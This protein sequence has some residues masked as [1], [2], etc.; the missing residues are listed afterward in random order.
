VK[1]CRSGS[2][3]TAAALWTGG[4]DSAFALHLALEAGYDVR[5]LVT[6]VPPR[7]Q[8]RAHPLEVMRLQAEALGLEHRTVTIRRPYRVS[9]G[10]ALSALRDEGITTLITGDIDR[11]GGDPNWIRDRARPLGLYVFT[12]LWRRSRTGVLRALLRA[13][14]EVIFSCT[15][16]TRLEEDWLGRIL[17]PSAIRELA[18]ISRSTGLD[19]AGEQGEFHTIALDAPRFRKRLVIRR[20]VPAHRGKWSYM[21]ILDMGLTAKRRPGGDRGASLR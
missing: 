17:D 18:S 4:K 11:I 19:P 8:F 21:R 5:Q 15:D 20:W 14:F 2:R 6:F 3:G 16:A 10:S 13:R 1:S 12:P 9:Y 7:A